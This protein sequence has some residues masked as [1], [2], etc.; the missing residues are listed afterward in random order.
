MGCTTVNPPRIETPMSFLYWTYFGFRTAL[1]VK[2]V[3]AGALRHTSGHLGRPE[4][5][6]VDS[7]VTPAGGEH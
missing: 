2:S 7:R 5:T 3:D 1:A 4:G 6:L